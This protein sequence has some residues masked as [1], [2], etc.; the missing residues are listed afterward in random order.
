MFHEVPCSLIYRLAYAVWHPGTPYLAV[1]I[2]DFYL[3][4]AQLRVDF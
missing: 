2:P 1:T 4:V 3:Y